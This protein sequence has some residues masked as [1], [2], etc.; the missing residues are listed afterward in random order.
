MWWGKVSQIM[1]ILDEV[2]MGT[3]RVEA[4]L[5]LRQSILVNSLL[6]S[7]EAWSNVTEKQLARLEVVD[8]A[9]LAQLTGGHAKTPSEFHH[10]ETGTWK[11]RHILSYLRLLFHHNIL[12]RD[13]NETIKKI[14]LKQKEECVKGDWFELLKQDFDFIGVNMNEEKI[15]STPKNQYKVEIKRLIQKAA[16]KYFTEIQATHQKIRDIKYEA[17]K[18]SNVF[19]GQ[20]YQLK[21]EGTSLYFEVSLPQVKT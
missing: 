11:L 9:F 4:G 16:F 1:G 20:I 5:L 8:S 2:D 10:L 14:Y 19:S 18:K 6:Y 17:L 21:R 3:N 13:D 12:S 7:A 15:S